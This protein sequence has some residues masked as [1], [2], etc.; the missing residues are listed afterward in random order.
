MWEQDDNVRAGWL[1]D[2]G[3]LLLDLDIARGT[4]PGI[5]IGK[6]G[7]GVAYLQDGTLRLSELGGLT[8]QCLPGRYCNQRIEGEQEE[9]SGPIELAYDEAAD[10]WF[11]VAG[12]ELIVVARGDRGPVTKQALVRDL[13]G[14]APNRVDVAVSGHSA[15]VVQAAKNGRSA[16][17]F[18]GCF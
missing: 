13:L 4:T 12:T 2:D 18:L 9:P 1:L 11:V 8:L 15:A 6:D 14:E 5:A 3:T 17:T 10:T 7:P 16:L